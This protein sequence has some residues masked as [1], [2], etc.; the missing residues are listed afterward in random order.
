MNSLKRFFEKRS[1]L[2]KIRF[3]LTLVVLVLTLVFLYLKIVPF[4]HITYK[5]DWP[6]G[7]ASGKGFISDFKPGERL[8]ENNVDSLKVIADPVYFSLFSPRTFDQAKVTVKY[9]DHLA[10]STPI[11]SIGVLKDKLSGN[12]DLRPLENKILDR[13]RFVWPRLE[14][15]GRRMILQSERNYADPADFFKDYEAGS[16][17]DCAVGPQDCVAV[18]NYQLPLNYRLPDYQLLQPLKITQPLKGAHQL[19]VYLKNEPW[20]FNF[21]FVRLRQDAASDPVVVNLIKNGQVV[22]S[23]SLAD[24]NLK[25]ASGIPEEETLTFSGPAS[26]A[27]VYRLEINIDDDTVI[28]DI[29]S[30]SDRLVFIGHV[31][32]V[33]TSGPLVLLTDSSVITTSTI[34]PASRQNILFAGKSFSLDKTYEP[35]SFSVKATG[36]KEIRLEKDDVKLSDSGVFSFN[37]VN[38]F[39][40]APEN[41][42][43]FF[44]P[45]E[46]IKYIVAG[47]DAPLSDN[48]I[49]KA[50]TYLD[51][52]GVARDEGNYYFALSV[53]GLKAGSGASLEIKEIKIELEGKT[54]FGKIGDWIKKI[55]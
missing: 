4:G 21:T 31:W 9:I 50:T 51:L 17:K 41:A 3:I 55:I 2:F 40:P 22:S 30:P 25:P 28:K 24:S 47:Y 32:P 38:F 20:R 54:I 35:I 33:S 39:N 46:N 48:G 12:Y 16:L 52:R 53:P 37:R 36:I 11:V 18:Y 10:S 14:D 45:A 8:G 43:R 5:L 34:D 44:S 49:T 15:N 19:Y 7:L 29:S 6:R 26:G 27:G 1:F 42:D 23:A 13:L